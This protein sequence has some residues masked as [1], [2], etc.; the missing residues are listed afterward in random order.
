MSAKELIQLPVWKGNRIIDH[1]HVEKIKSSLNNDIKRLDFSYRIATYSE[2]DA[3]NNKILKSYIIDGQHRHKIL[4]DY[5]TTILCEPDFEVVVIEKEFES[6]SDVIEYFNELNNSKP[7]QWS[8][9]VML[10]NRYSAELEAVFNKKKSDPLI[11]PATTKRPYLSALKIREA[12]LEN[13]EKLKENKAEIAAFVKRV[14]EFNQAEIKN[15]DFIILNA[16]KADIDI[17]QRAIKSGFM[18]AIGQKLRWVA[19]LL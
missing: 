11:R 7:I 16:K 4:Q 13:S 14:V 3:G 2:F 9:P 8:D 6:E 15:S 19:N 18:L 5:F 12:L 1:A 10:A 17:I